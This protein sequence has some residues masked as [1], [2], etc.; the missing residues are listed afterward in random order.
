MQFYFIRHAQ[1]TN[2][3]LWDVTRSSSGRDEDPELTGIGQEQARLLAGFLKTGNPLGG[4]PTPGFQTGFGLT[5]LYCSLMARS[6]ATGW[7]VS[8]ALGIPLEALEDVHE[9]GGIYLEDAESGERVG[10]P[11]KNRAYFES[12]YPGIRLPETLGEAGW[13]NNR[14]FEVEEAR[15]ERARRFVAALLEKHGSR[16]DRVAVISHGGFYNRVLAAILG[17]NPEARVWGVLHNTGITR[18]D[19]ERGYTDLLYMNRTDFLPA[20]LLT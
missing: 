18:I 16:P 12:T 7:I 8:Q 3:A 6:A 14:P 20:D 17:L 11:G 15:V 13:W 2:N 19:F 9:E 10:L 4:R 1:S 5:H